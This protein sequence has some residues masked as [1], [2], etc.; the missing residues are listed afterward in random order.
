MNDILAKKTF[1]IPNKL[2]NFFEL[3]DLQVKFHDGFIEAGLTPHFIFPKTPVFKPV[4]SLEDKG[5]F[6]FVT[7]ISEDGKISSKS[8]KEPEQFL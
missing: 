8:L 3:T 5:Y 2:F 7:S 4:N 6:N 1:M